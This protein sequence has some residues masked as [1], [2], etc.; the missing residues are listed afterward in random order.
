MIKIYP[1]LMI[2]KIKAQETIKKDLKIVTEGAKTKEKVQKEMKIIM[3]KR[4][5]ISGKYLSKKFLK[6]TKI[7]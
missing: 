2:I 3:I 4:R 1:N 6:I 7:L 5:G